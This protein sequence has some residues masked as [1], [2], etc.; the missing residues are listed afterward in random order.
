[1]AGSL[2]DHALTEGMDFL[3]EP[4]QIFHFAVNTK[5]IDFAPVLLLL[6]F[7]TV[8]E[9]TNF[10]HSP[11]KRLL[12]GVEHLP[13][14]SLTVKEVIPFPHRVIEGYDAETITRPLD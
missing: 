5:N 8:D 10:T 1:M 6:V 11:A 2:L 7:L 12:F 3:S 4:N 13:E 14:T 9:V